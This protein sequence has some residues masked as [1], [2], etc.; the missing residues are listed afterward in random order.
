MKLIATLL[1]FSGGLSVCCAND[2]YAIESGAAINFSKS[3]HVQMVE[4]D[5]S[6]NLRKEDASVQVDFVFKNHGPAHNVLMAFP[7][8]GYSVPTISDFKS[9]VGGMPVKVTFRKISEVPEYSSE[10]AWTKNVYFEQGQT[11][12]VR[13]SYTI[14][15]SGSTSTDRSL[16]YILKSGATW[17]GPIKRTTINVD[18][19]KAETKYPVAFIQKFGGGE[20][21][22]LV[23]SEDWKI[24][25]ETGTVTFR[26]FTPDFDIS[27]GMY[28]GYWN[29]SLN[30]ELVRYPRN[31]LTTWGG[32]ED[33]LIPVDNVAE[34]FAD[35][36]GT[37]WANPLASKFGGSITFPDDEAMLLGGRRRVELPRPLVVKWGA[38]VNN[39][40]FGVKMVRLRDLVE[41]LGWTYTY[42]PSRGLIEITLT[43]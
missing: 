15:Y 3:A 30:R 29:I 40:D 24:N 22:K 10:G 34:L 19:S 7:D 32:P 42:V 2:A 18:W 4:E 20:Y 14:G 1:A 8:I 28:P 6:V 27:L 43:S 5:I 36:E 33:L 9:W 37:Q 23:P 35:R 25:G 12:H 21:P 17:K 13:V 41:A 11:R 16:D 38:H 39:P 26:N 31:Y